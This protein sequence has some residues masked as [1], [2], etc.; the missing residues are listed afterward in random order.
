M[1]NLSMYVLDRSAVFLSRKAIKYF[2]CFKNRNHRI[3]KVM[4]TYASRLKVIETGDR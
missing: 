3:S 1:Y 4:L 2:Y